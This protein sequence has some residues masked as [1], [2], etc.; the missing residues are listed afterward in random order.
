LA[1]EH[2]CISDLIKAADDCLYQAKSLGR[3]QVFYPSVEREE[4]AVSGDEKAA[5]MGMFSDYQ[6]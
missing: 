2:G 6:D 3:N 1:H 4:V 5:L